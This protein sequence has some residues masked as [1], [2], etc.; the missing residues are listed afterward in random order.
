MPTRSGARIVRPNCWA[1]LPLRFGIN[2]NQTLF[3]ARDHFGIKPLIYHETQRRF[4]ALASE[5]RAILA[6][7]Q[8]P[9]RINEGRIADFLIT[10]LEGIDKTSTFFEEVYR[11]PPAHTVTI[12]P[13]GMTHDVDIGH[14]NPVPSCACRQTRN[15]LRHFL[16]YSPKR[17]AA[18]CVGPG[19]LGPCSAGGWI[20]ARSSL[21]PGHCWPRRAEGPL[22]YFFRRITGRR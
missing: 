9:Y 12:T 5:P 1:H 8:T 13:A 4:F 20:P 18:D 15:M 16:R 3:C 10:Q 17:Y 2:A 21:W 14:L 7:P 11:L 19:P 22:R 6:L